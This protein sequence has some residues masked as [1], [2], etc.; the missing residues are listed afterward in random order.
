M[1][2]NEMKEFCKKKKIEVKFTDDRYEELSYKKAIEEAGLWKE[3][4]KKAKEE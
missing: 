1:T 4:D 2:L 3:F